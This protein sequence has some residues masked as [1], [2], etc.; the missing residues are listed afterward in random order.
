[1]TQIVVSLSANVAAMPLLCRPWKAL[2][3]ARRFYVRKFF[4]SHS[5]PKCPICAGGAI[6]PGNISGRPHSPTI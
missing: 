4:L 3:P 1:M 5:V 2:D 6:A